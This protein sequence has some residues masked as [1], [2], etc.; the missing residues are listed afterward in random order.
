MVKKLGISADQR[1]KMDD[2]FQQF[3]VKL[4]DL[5]AALDKEEGAL[6]PMMQS[7]QLDDSKILPQIDRI[8]Q[9]RSDL[10]KVE[11]RLMLALRHVLT[12][13]QWDMLQSEQGLPNP[14]RPPRE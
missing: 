6:E 13:E 5:H 3:R 1:K 9:A 4:V 7:G 12:P 2:G 10:E 14:R 11:A 8:A